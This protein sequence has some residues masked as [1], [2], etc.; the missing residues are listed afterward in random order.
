MEQKVVIV[1]LDDTLFIRSKITK[2]FFKLSKLVFKTGVRFEK[3]NLGLLKKLD[4]YDVKIVLTARANDWMRK[5]TLEQLSR[6][7]IEIDGIIFCPRGKLY[8]EWKKEIISKLKKKHKDLV[9]I[10]YDVN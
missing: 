8:V 1:D 10:D 2:F 5:V 7:K 6:W 3:I 9:W 4:E